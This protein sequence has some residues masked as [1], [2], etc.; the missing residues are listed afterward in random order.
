MALMNH[1]GIVKE[2]GVRNLYLIFAQSRM[3]VIQMT[4]PKAN[5]QLTQL[6]YESYLEAMVR[7]SLL[8]ALPTDK[9]LKKK[10]FSYPG[11]YIGA[12]LNRGVSMLEAWIVTSKKAQAMGKADPSFRRVDMMILV[13]VSVMQFGVEV[14]PGGPSILLR[15][16]PDEILSLEEVTRYWKKPTPSVF[17]EMT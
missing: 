10:C 4:N 8:K 11:E 15:G 14:Q 9:E 13:I 16:H 1:I 6:T 3:A 7:L 12:I 2:V 17:E 5:Q